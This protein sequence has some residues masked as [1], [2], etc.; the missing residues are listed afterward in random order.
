MKILVTGSSGFL[1]SN[2]IKKFR[3]DGH[4]TI[5]YD[6]SNPRFSSCIPDNSFRANILDEVALET[7]LNCCQPDVIFHL[8]AFATIQDGLS[9]SYTTYSVNVN[10]T[11]ALLNAVNRVKSPATVIYASTDKVYGS[12]CSGKKYTENLPLN[13]NTNSVYDVSKA[14]ADLLVQEWIKAGGNGIIVRF[15]NLYGP[16]DLH[17]SR[18]V[19]ASIIAVLENRPPVLKRYR[20]AR[21]EPLCDFYRDML[22]VDDLC[23]GLAS[24]VAGRAELDTHIFNFGA[25]ECVSMSDVIRDI[26]KTA[27]FSDEPI[28][29]EADSSIE[30]ARQSMDYSQANRAFGFVPRTGLD[31]GIKLTY[32]WWIDYMKEGYFS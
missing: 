21:E 20:P 29:R 5:G 23:E 2:L 1:G 9:D 7:V 25:S 3:K 15:C 31:E 26:C 10:G 6:I 4:F 13:P 12:I 16:Y 28:I 32:K 8:A 24:L 14:A 22:Y 17:S 27:S 30:L 18:I 11:R 19:P